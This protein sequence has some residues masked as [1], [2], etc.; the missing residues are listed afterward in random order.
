MK[1][2]RVAIM[3]STPRKSSSSIHPRPSECL[4]ALQFVA[5]LSIG[6]NGKATMEHVDKILIHSIS[7]AFNMPLRQ[8]CHRQTLVEQMSAREERARAAL[9]LVVDRNRRRDEYSLSPDN[10]SSSHGVYAFD[11]FFATAK[12]LCQRVSMNAR[13]HGLASPVRSYSPPNRAGRERLHLR[14]SREFREK[15][16]MDCRG[17]VEREPNKSAS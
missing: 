2:M 15:G 14:S 9:P 7:S 1:P 8:R 13:R 4:A 11:C 5:K 6:L 16:A 12:L 10:I 3:Q 17:P